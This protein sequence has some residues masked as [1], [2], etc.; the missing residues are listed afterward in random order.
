MLEYRLQPV[1]S[2]NINNYLDEQI[3]KQ[4]II[5]PSVEEKI[6]FDNKCITHTVYKHAVNLRKWQEDYIEFKNSWGSFISNEGNFSVTDLK[7]LLCVDNKINNDRK[8]ISL[9]FNFDKIIEPYKTRIYEK[10]HIYHPTFDDLLETPENIHYSGEYNI[11][12]LFEGEGKLTY[13]DKLYEGEWINGIKEG[14]GIYRY[15]DGRYYEGEWKNDK[16]EGHGIYRYT[17]GRYY[18]GE[19]KN[20][21]KEGQGFFNFL[22]GGSYNG[23]WKNDNKEGKGIYIFPNKDIYEGEFKKGKTEGY[24]IYKF[25]DGTIHKGIWNNNTLVKREI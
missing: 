17:D 13:L 10:Y 3:H 14:R 6:N 2:I 9:M 25:A 22:D 19:W 18:E 11:Y 20:D 7:Y 1:V 21:K 24:G 8:F 5:L 12:G 4:T 15:T 16:K 23:E